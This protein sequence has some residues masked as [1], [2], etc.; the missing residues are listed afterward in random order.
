MND[1]ELLCHKRLG[2]KNEF[3]PVIF[4][5]F[6]VKYFS[7]FRVFGVFRGYQSHPSPSPSSTCATGGTGYK[8]N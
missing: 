4:G 3:F 7:I 1:F 2:P 6:V 5:F 8:N